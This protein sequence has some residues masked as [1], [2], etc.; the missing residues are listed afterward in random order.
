MMYFPS[1]ILSRANNLTS[2]TIN[3]LFY[4]ETR[5]QMMT[6][7]SQAY[8][9]YY[10]VLQENSISVEALRARM[11]GGLVSGPHG[12]SVFQEFLRRMHGESQPH[13]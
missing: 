13:A 2:Y 6:I 3:H 1:L 8:G 9:D 10:E 4:Q 5:D 11:G 12:E 7:Y